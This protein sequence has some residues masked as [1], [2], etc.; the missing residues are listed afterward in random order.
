MRQAGCRNTRN[1][2][3]LPVVMMHRQFRRLLGRRGLPAAAKHQTGRRC[4]RAS[5]GRRPDFATSLPTRC[6]DGAGAWR[7]Y[8]REPKRDRLPMRRLLARLMFAASAALMLCPPAM[9]QQRTQYEAMVA[10]HA[11]ANLVPEALVHRVIVRESKYQPALIGRGGTIGLMQIKLATARSLGYTGSAEGLRDPETNLAYGIT[12]P[13]RRLSRRQWRSRP[14]GTLLCRRLLP[15]G[16]APAART[17]KADPR[18][19]RECTAKGCRT[20]AGDGQKPSPTPI[21]KPRRRQHRARAPYTRVDT[22]AHRPT[23]STFRGV[24]RRR[25]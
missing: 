19:A 12:I 1:T 11:Q 18:C 14:R 17:C 22:S 16:E 20:P 10:T 23:L 4:R 13:R 24:L 9:A 7:R 15:R 21:R 8:A 5:R 6:D 2:A 25:S 3:G